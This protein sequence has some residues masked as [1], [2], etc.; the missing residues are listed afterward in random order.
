MKGN[1]TAPPHGPAQDA[2]RARHS[3]AAV[4]ARYIQD[5]TQPA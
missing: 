5:L 1:D 2:I 3:L 4:V